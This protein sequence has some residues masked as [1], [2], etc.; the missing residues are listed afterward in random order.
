MKHKW[1]RNC[2]YCNLCFCLTHSLLHRPNVRYYN[3]FLG[4]F[5]NLRTI[6]LSMMIFWLLRRHYNYH[7]NRKN[8]FLKMVSFCLFLLKFSVSVLYVFVKNEKK[9]PIHSIIPCEFTSLCYVFHEFCFCCCKTH[10]VKSMI[11][12]DFFRSLV[13][14]YV[15][16]CTQNISIV[17]VFFADCSYR[18]TALDI[19][20]CVHVL[21]KVTHTATGDETNIIQHWTM[22]FP[23]LTVFIN[24]ALF[25]VYHIFNRWPW[26]R[27]LL[28]NYSIWNCALDWLKFPLVFHF[29]I[30]S[31]S[32]K[33]SC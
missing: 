5:I 25:W 15:F 6:V 3:N 2:H 21:V 14:V 20:F 23:L 8:T 30:I 4:K 19:Q 12:S 33:N 16:V 28:L 1:N 13:G 9:N 22:P 18:T 17:G 31:N 24:N 7:H 27:E 29:K 32:L 11:V 10:R 26:S